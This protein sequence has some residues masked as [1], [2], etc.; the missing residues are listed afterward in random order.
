MTDADIL[1]DERPLYVR[2]LPENGLV[3]VRSPDLARQQMLTRI[4]FAHPRT[5]PLAG[6]CLALGARR[7][8]VNQNLQ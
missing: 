7:F 3:S 4:S 2:A 8:I 5:A 6:Y 1:N